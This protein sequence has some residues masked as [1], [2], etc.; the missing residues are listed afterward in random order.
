MRIL[1]LL[2]LAALFA[3]GEAS[4]KDRTPRLELVSSQPIPAGKWEARL[5]AARE[6]ERRLLIGVRYVGD[7]AE[8]VLTLGGPVVVVPARIEGAELVATD[9]SIADGTSRAYSAQ[10]ELERLAL[11]F[12]GDGLEG[13][14]A[15]TCIRGDCD[16]PVTCPV[17]EMFSATLAQQTPELLEWPNS[18]LSPGGD[19]L[20]VVY[21]PVRLPARAS[22]EFGDQRIDGTLAGAGTYGTELRVRPER[23]LPWGRTVRVSAEV[24][25]IVGNRHVL[26][27][28]ETIVDAPVASPDP[29]LRT[30]DGYAITGLEPLRPDEALE[31]LGREGGVSAHFEAVW[32]LAFETLVPDSGTAA[33]ELDLVRANGGDSRGGPVEVKVVGENGLAKESIDF[34]DATRRAMPEESEFAYVEDVATRTPLDEFRGERVVVSVLGLAHFGGG[35]CGPLE[36]SGGRTVVSRAEIVP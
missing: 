5:P 23:P 14:A 28:E 32:V 25:D 24:E 3:C 13:T 36:P 33:L 1:L 6:G 11:R 18:W 35:G 7:A 10:Y 16:T 30:L 26:S 9:I 22:I 19:L 27:W 34:D 2:L 4:V 17:T 12:T 8:L 21:E 31:L 20:G 29:Q 15:G